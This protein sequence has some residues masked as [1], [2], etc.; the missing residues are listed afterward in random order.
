MKTPGRVR[1]SE[2]THQVTDGTGK[3]AEVYAKVANGR[4]ISYRTKVLPKE[5]TS[6]KE[7]A[8]VSQKNG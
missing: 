1:T 5:G 6:R 8:W 2:Q 4:D 7:F 3:H